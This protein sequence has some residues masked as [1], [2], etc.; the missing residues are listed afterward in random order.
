MSS[1]QS[2]VYGDRV[3]YSPLRH[4]Y[5]ND[6]TMSDQSREMWCGF[7][8]RINYAGLVLNWYQ[9]PIGQKYN[10]DNLY[11]VCTVVRTIVFF[12]E[13][14]L[15]ELFFTFVKPFVKGAFCSFVEEL[16]MRRER[17]VLADF[18]LNKLNSCLCFH[19]WINWI[20]KLSLKDKVL[21]CLCGGPCHLPS[22]SDL[23]P[24]TPL[25]TACLF[26]LDKKFV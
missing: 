13:S 22:N 17:C 19:D 6:L 21:L 15:N 8:I 7:T 5:F 3:S 25:R 16:L 11:A 12:F 20:N 23:E 26:S 10:S 2:R 18:L 1:L 9:L 14:V 24:F 4:R